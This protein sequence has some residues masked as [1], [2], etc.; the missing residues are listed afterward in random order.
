MPTVPQME[1]ARGRDA[2]RDRLSEGT[3][4]TIDRL[5]V[6]LVLVGACLAILQ[7]GATAGARSAMT[8]IQIEQ[9]RAA[10]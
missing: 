5:L 8:T 2:L 6:A 1:D 4:R 9:G 10:W 7:M 3:R